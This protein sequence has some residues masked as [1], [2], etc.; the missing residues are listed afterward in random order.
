MK[1]KITACLALIV[2][3]LVGICVHPVNAAVTND[4]GGALRGAKGI[5]IENKGVKGGRFWI[6]QF[7]NI[8]GGREDELFQ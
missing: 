1:V 7:V 6:R 4:G 2:E 5:Q 3:V 8:N